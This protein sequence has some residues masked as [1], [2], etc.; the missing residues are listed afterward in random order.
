MGDGDGDDGGFG[1]PDFTPAIPAA[2]SSDVAPPPAAQRA[3]L[4]PG[5][6]GVVVLRPSRQPDD[7]PAAHR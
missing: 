5:Y 3:F 6:R 1:G 7:P 4:G 2:E